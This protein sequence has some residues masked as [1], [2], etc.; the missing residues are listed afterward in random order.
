MSEGIAALRQRF[1]ENS[2][3]KQRNADP[4]PGDF[5]SEKRSDRCKPAFALAGGRGFPGDD[6]QH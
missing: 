4:S 6:F 1:G 2:T 3:V 5:I